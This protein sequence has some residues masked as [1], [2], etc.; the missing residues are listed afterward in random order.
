MAKTKTLVV[1]DIH[2]PFHDPTYVSLF[3]HTVRV[4]KPD[5]VLLN[6]DIADIYHPSVYPK[7][8]DVTESYKIEDEIAC[9]LKFLKDLRRAA[10]DQCEIIYALGNHEARFNKYVAENAP[11]IANLLRLEHYINTERQIDELLQYGDIYQF[12]NTQLYATHSPPSY[13]IYA[14]ATSLKEKIGKSY[15][16]GC[17]HRPDVAYK[18]RW[19]K[20]HFEID[21]VY[22]NGFLGNKHLSP[23]HK[24]VF[25]YEKNDRSWPTIMMVTILDGV[26]FWVEQQFMKGDMIAINGKIIKTE[27]KWK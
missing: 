26:H 13:A 12:E 2:V 6:G 5:R 9:L 19:D 11:I 1:S 18:K 17:T 21:T 4:T 15:I 3:M 14:A 20:D 24:A 10:G 8:A 22:I 7:D 27:S 23:A 25:S 16:Y